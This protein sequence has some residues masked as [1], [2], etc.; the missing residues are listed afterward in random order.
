MIVKK[1]YYLDEVIA[2]TPDV[3]IFRFK[4]TDGSSLDFEP[5]MFIMLYYKA[6]TPDEIGRAYSIASAPGSEIIEL[7]ISMVHGRLTSKLEE[8][9]VGDIYH[10]SGPY[11][12]FKFNPSANKKVLFIAGGTGISPFMSML[13]FIKSR[14]LQIDVS[15]LYSVRYP[16]EIIR[17]SELEELEKSI[18]AK[19]VVTVTRPQPGDN[20]N[21]ETGHINEDMVRRRVPDFMERDPY[22]CGPPAF[23][24]AMKQVLKNIGIEES[25]IRA[26]MWG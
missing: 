12:Q 8:A 2:E 17:R 26:E 22:I 7:F 1:P 16:Y 11:G 21:G 3:K 13:R 23:S 15:L 19:I 20:W 10:I 24:N 9:K 18:G 14:G 6:N 5:G 4:S 25:K